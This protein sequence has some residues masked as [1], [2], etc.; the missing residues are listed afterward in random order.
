MSHSRTPCRLKFSQAVFWEEVV[1][2]SSTSIPMHTLAQT[3]IFLAG[4]LSV[5]VVPVFITVINC[6]CKWACR[7]SAKAFE[8]R[9]HSC[10]VEK[11]FPALMELQPLATFEGY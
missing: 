2:L 1:S 7:F 3:C 8:V 10:D 5:P 4:L 11:L 9:A 6:F